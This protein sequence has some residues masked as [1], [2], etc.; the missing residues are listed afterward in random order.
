MPEAWLTRR[1]RRKPDAKSSGFTLNHPPS[2]LN[3]PSRVNAV[4]PG[5]GMPGPGHG[6]GASLVPG[7]PATDPAAGGRAAAGSPWMMDSRSGLAAAQGRAATR[8]SGQRQ[9]AARLR[10]RGD[11]FH[12]G[13]INAVA[14]LIE[15]EFQVRM[16]GG[17]PAVAPVPPAP[18]R[19]RFSEIWISS[20]PPPP[21]PTLQDLH[22]SP[23]I[24]RQSAG[25][26]G[27]EASIF[28]RLRSDPSAATHTPILP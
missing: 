25:K 15:V 11:N 13:Q 21:P 17:L 19:A 20:A 5:P 3:F 9:Q 7:A 28:G 2:T 4:R 1:M 26:G 24:T 14:K 18:P 10:H 23:L 22:S 8:Q 6:P 16:T 12:R 27:N